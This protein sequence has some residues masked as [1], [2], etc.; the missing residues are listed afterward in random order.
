MASRWS[1]RVALSAAVATGAL[2]RLWNLRDQ[3][4]GDDELHAVRAALRHPAG[5]LW[6]S[7]EKNDNCL[8]LTL[9]DRLWM[10]SGQPLT[11]LVLRL[12]VL[13]CGLALL[14]WLPRAVERRLGG[15]VALALAWLLALS[16]LLVL[17]SRIA[18]SYA[19][20]TLFGSLAAM[21]FLRW[22]LSGSRAAGALYALFAALTV[23][24]HLIAAPFVL[25]PWLFAAGD[26]CVRP[27]TS[28]RPKPLQILAVALA[29]AAGL[30]AFLLP[31]RESLGALFAVKSGEGALTSETLT[32]L[33]SLWAGT[34]QPLLGLLFWAAALAGL[35]L[36][37]RRQS[38][39]AVFSL[40][41][42]VAQ[43]LGLAV[44][45]PFLVEIPLIFSRYMIVALPLVLLWVA[46]ALA[47]PW[48]AWPRPGPR[49]TSLAAAAAIVAL[50]LLSGPLADPAVRSSSFMHADDYLDF[51]RPYPTL[52][53]Q[54]A[55]GF[56]RQPP[57]PGP[58]VEG[59]WPTSWKY[60][61]TLL[62]D[63]R[64][65]GQRVIAAPY[66]ETLAD[67]RLR[68]R[69]ALATPD[70]MLASEARWVVIHRDLAAEELQLPDAQAARGRYAVRA[71]QEAERQRAWAAQMLRLLP[72]RWGAP[73]FEDERIAVWDLEAV[74][75]RGGA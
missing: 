15:G 6:R 49:A 19:P 32:G 34:R 35:I 75:A 45:A 13:L 60:G 50:P 39:L 38:R 23:Y 48:T 18:R 54:A 59:P 66:D 29:T 8:P 40:V 11:E 46:V 31:A 12:P 41:L 64:L 21:S 42:V 1:A 17:Y 26:L 72:A 43:L 68:F 36:L 27:R 44:A 47:A 2:A 62:V 56:Y 10:D 71:A 52:P 7:Y 5:T 25:A 9:L 51:T 3:V 53:P 74:R 22:W 70:A 57:Q 37:W 33:A 58:I 4:A 73:V 14:W 67:P 16:P 65:H 30:A 55:S 63:E 20:I 61:R 69:N 28:A 24:F